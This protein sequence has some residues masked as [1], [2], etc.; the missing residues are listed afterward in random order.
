MWKEN[1]SPAMLYVND[2]EVEASV[3][4]LNAEQS[5]DGESLATRCL[6]TPTEAIGE[7]DQ[8]SI[9]V[10]GELTSYAGVNQGEDLIYDVK[11]QPLS[12]KSPE[13]VTL[14]KSRTE[15]F[16]VSVLPASISVSQTLNVEVHGDAVTAEVVCAVDDEGGALVR[17]TGVSGGTARLSLAIAGMKTGAEVQVVCVDV[18]DYTAI[19]LPE[20][21][22][23]IGAKPSAA[24]TRELSSCRK[25][26]NTS[27]VAP[28]RTVTTCCTLCCPT[29]RPS[30]C[31]RTLTTQTK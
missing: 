1:E 12:V 21:L 10:S 17:V 25:A 19:R 15:E 2:K 16:R 3:T 29:A 31:P 30:M 8:V 22:T 27:T 5:P 9:V 24:P 20:E 13:S 26:A 14:L 6:M 18:N 11:R 28:S 4:V 7:A 23:E